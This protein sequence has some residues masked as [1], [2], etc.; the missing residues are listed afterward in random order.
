M[1][2]VSFT[3]VL[4]LW[5]IYPKCPPLLNLSIADVV[6]EIA[7]SLDKLF[8]S[9]NAEKKLRASKDTN[10]PDLYAK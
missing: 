3:A 6:R 1:H 7:F 4:T 2:Q 5:S 8:V 10:P 9:S